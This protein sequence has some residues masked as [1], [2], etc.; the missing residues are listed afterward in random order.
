[1][2]RSK[3][4][5]APYCFV[6]VRLL[7]AAPACA[8]A[9]CSNPQTP[10]PQGRRC[11]RDSDAHPA[12]TFQSVCFNYSTRTPHMHPGTRA[13]DPLTEYGQ[14]PASRPLSFELREMA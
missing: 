11:S 2:H 14:S 3:L 7:C 10:R 5:S 12:S 6:F 4:T 8:R 13:D 9:C 1:M